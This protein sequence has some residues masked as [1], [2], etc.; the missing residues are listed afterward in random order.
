MVVYESRRT[1]GTWSTPTVHETGDRTLLLL[2]GWKH[3]GG[4]DAKTGELLWTY[5]PQVP[6][7]WAVHGCCDVVNRGVAYDPRTG[8][9]VWLALTILALLGLGVVFV[10]PQRVA[11]KVPSP[12]PESTV[13][14]SLPK[15]TTARS[16]SPS[17]SRSL[18]P[19][20]SGFAD[21]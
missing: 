12:A 20:E 5:D 8:R 17:S 7:D 2:N 1:T 18:T 4:Y 13:T 11:E 15:H 16:K 6:R 14:Q 19:M 9:G 3:A 10:L 21:V